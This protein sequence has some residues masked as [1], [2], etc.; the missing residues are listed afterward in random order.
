MYEKVLWHG[1]STDGPGVYQSF[2]MLVQISEGIRG[3]AVSLQGVLICRCFDR[4]YSAGFY[5]EVT[6]L[7]QS[8]ISPGW[9][10]D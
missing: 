4:A 1:H 5:S 10:E 2:E 8:F 7:V 9:N 6:V 3:L